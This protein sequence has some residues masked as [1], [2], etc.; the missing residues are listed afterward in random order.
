MKYL[1]VVFSLFLMA[2]CEV[3]SIKKVGYGKTLDTEVNAACFNK[4]L[5]NFQNST[6]YSLSVRTEIQG[7]SVL[8]YDL[9]IDG[10]GTA[11]SHG[12]FT[13]NSFQLSKDFLAQLIEQCSY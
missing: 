9:T 7:S 6:D 10:Q 8:S 11:E 5:G 3:N 13:R 4:R 12:Q 1:F 2:G